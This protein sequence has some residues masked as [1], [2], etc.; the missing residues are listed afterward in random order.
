ME[1]VLQ[2]SKAAQSGISQLPGE[3]MAPFQGA[4]EALAVIH[5]MADV[6]VLSEDA[7][8]DVK[9]EWTRHDLLKYADV[10]LGG[11]LGGKHRRI[12]AM[13]RYGYQPDHV[14]V[15]GD[16][17]EDWDAAELNDVGFFPIVV[18]QEKE[19]WHELQAVG[20]EKLR[21]LSYQDYQPEAKQRFLA[22]LGA[23]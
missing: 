16:T 15:V 8:E 10:L 11:D 9:A 6:A 20:L 1:K 7:Y 18:N 19:S 23:I 3:L 13:L 14:L 22:G 4:R 12:G 17:P 5:E 2:W 21:N